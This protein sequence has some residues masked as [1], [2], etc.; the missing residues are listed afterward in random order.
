MRRGEPRGLEA[1]GKEGF[2]VMR[3][4]HDADHAIPSRRAIERQ[5]KDPWAYRA[6][7][8]CLEA[9]G[10]LLD[11]V[12]VLQSVADTW[13]EGH[14]YLAED[15]A[16]CER[17]RQCGYRIMADTTIRL[18]HVG[19]CRYGWEDGGTDRPRVGSFNLDLRR[20]P[21]KAPPQGQAGRGVPISSRI[22]A[23]RA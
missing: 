7:A 17:A 9:R 12:A 19:S 8:H 21:S 15:F 2:F 13:Q 5:R 20:R 18:W 23:N 16:F 3:R 22:R 14:W 11:G 4:N 1:I 6:L 10:R